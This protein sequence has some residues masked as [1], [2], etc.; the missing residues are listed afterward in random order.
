MLVGGCH[1][2]LVRFTTA[3]TPFHETICHCAD[4]RRVSG[5]ASV[6][7]FSIRRAEMSWTA[8]TPSAYRSSPGLVRRFC[9]ACGTTFTFED[10]RHPEE[11]DLATA[12][13]DD[14]SAV[15]PKDHVF[16]SQAPTWD[17]P[18]D[19]LPAY[20]RSRREG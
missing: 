13:L 18:G 11:I 20:R 7:W 17:V 4:C 2:G 6:A 5:A 10:D 19:G 15:P 12:T 9:G 16:V 8:G 1:C 14:P 3:G